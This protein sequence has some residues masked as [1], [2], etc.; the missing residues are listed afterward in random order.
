MKKNEILCSVILNE[1][2]RFRFVLIGRNATY[3]T[4]HSKLRSKLIQQ[5]SFPESVA[6]V[7]TLPTVKDTSISIYEQY[8]KRATVHININ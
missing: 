2:S 1:I 4:D 6:T 5:A 7:V 8:V 3:P